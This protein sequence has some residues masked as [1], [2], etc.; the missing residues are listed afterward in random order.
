MTICHDRL[1][2]CRWPSLLCAGITFRMKLF[3]FS[4]SPYA[5][6][7]RAVLDLLGVEYEAVEVP[8][9]DRSELVAVT[10]GYLQVP[11]LVN[12][13]EVLT[14]SRAICEQ[15]LERDARLTPSPF[16]GPIWA[17]ADF[18][19]GPLEDV[20]FRIATPSLVGRK[21]TPQERALFVYVKERKFG[22]GCVQQ[23]A[24]EHAG[25]I[26]KG[27]KLLEP[28]ARTLEAQPFLFGATPT[29]ADAAL[30]GNLV[31]LAAADPVLPAQLGHVFPAF[32]ERLEERCRAE[33]RRQ[34][35]R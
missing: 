29:L 32:V 34:E 6:K 33:S 14:D 26:A 10:G 13:A 15:L 31:M 8:Y 21:A 25:L 35:S 5:R 11:V 17:Y 24:A 28:T 19:D 2:T 3:E 16:E 12:E 18:C 27:R 30:Y 4:Y 7:V 22:S 23:W 9:G 1:R 20:L